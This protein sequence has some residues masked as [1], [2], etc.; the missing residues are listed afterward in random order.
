[1]PTFTPFLDY[2]S[3]RRATR[4]DPPF[5]RSQRNVTPI[6]RA[7]RMGTAFERGTRHID[8]GQAQT[9]I[10]SFSPTRGIC[11][12]KLRTTHGG[13]LRSVEHSDR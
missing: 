3:Q 9:A 11:V 8:I 7:G 2:T 4:F 5:R 10:M 13:E 12:V 1:M 6:W